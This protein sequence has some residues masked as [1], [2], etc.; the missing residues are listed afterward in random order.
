MGYR[1]RATGWM[2]G[3]PHTMPSPD[4]E[5]GRNLAAF[6]PEAMRVELAIVHELYLPEPFVQYAS[7]VCS[8]RIA[9]PAKLPWLWNATRPQPK[10]VYLNI[11]RNGDPGYSW[12][13][14]TAPDSNSYMSRGGGCLFEE[15]VDDACEVLCISRSDLTAP[16]KEEDAARDEESRFA[17]NLMIIRRTLWLACRLDE[18]RVEV[19]DVLHRRKPD[20]LPFVFDTIVALR[21][22]LADADTGD[23]HALRTHD[24][25]QHRVGGKSGLAEWLLPNGGLTEAETVD[26]KSFEREWLHAMRVTP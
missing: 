23:A 8:A 13:V 16:S 17:D 18:K 21:K 22:L 11:V 7:G 9:D 1:R 19:V 4:R 2:G 25:L 14:D 5:I 20:Y 3:T 24:A 15:T 12:Y 10:D 26:I 6:T